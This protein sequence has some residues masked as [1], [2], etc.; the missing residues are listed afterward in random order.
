MHCTYFYYSFS[1]QSEYK[2]DEGI[3]IEPVS[4]K[5]CAFVKIK[6]RKF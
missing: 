1:I 3:D 5:C 6:K 2:K 4:Q